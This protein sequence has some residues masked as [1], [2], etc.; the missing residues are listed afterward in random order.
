MRFDDYFAEQMKSPAFKKAYEAQ[1]KHDD[2]RMKHPCKRHHKSHSTMGPVGGP[3]HWCFECQKEIKNVDYE[4]EVRML[5]RIQR[6]DNR[7]KS[8]KRKV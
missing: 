2:W 3:I 8:T 7:I 1:K 4:D 5:K 6:H